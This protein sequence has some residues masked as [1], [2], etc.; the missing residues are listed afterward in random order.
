MRPA[1]YT[2]ESIVSAGQ[3][4]QAAGR[5]ITGFAIRQK[6]GGGNPTRLKQIWDE[7]ANSQTTTQFEPA[8]ELPV[9]VAQRL[10]ESTR[11]LTERLAALATEMNT[12]AVQ[13][14]ERRTG[15]VVRSAAEQR[16]QADRELADAAQ[17]LDDLENQLD[18]ANAGAEELKARLAETQATSQG[19]AIELA[20][21]RERLAQTEQAAGKAAQDHADELTRLH[22]AVEAAVA[23]HRIELAEQKKITQE[24]AVERDQARAELATVKAKAEAADQAHQ[25]Q[26]KQG[27]AETHRAAERLGKSKTERDEARKEAA[28]AR[29]DAARLHGQVE[30]LQLQ[31]KP[32]RVKS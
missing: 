22:A 31:L 23:R 12:I 25:E 28:Q 1:E 30:A 20:Q 13:T 4:L 29:E 19:Q 9:E 8:A 11:V 16:E 18:Q 15:E 27:A 10:T 26:R 14:A 32:E 2:S 6:I 24:T 17:T 7:H 5:S 21:L 3:E